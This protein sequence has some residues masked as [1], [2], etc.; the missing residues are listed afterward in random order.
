MLTVKVRIGRLRAMK[1]AQRLFSTPYT[2]QVLSAVISACLL[3][4]CAACGSKDQN[5]NPSHQTIVD[6]PQAAIHEQVRTGSDNDA[7]SWAIG[8]YGLKS[9]YSE[10]KETGSPTVTFVHELAEFGNISD[11][12]DTVKISVE[13]EFA[14][15]TSGIRLGTELPTTLI[16]EQGQIIAANRIAHFVTTKKDGVRSVSIDADAENWAGLT[17][18]SSAIA[19]GVST[20]G[21]NESATGIKLKVTFEKKGKELHA[22]VQGQLSESEG[23]DK[24][25]YAHLTYVL[26]DAK[27]P[28][29]LPKDAKVTQVGA[30]QK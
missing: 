28:A 6:V 27:S 14:A 4:F 1:S 20:G 2:T 21:L 13:G 24:E 10:A 29:T 8:T 12:N 11:T 7:A 5:S 15:N 16:V 25:L 18:L 26:L 22:F 17:E 3:A 19:L 30:G 23:S 9:Y